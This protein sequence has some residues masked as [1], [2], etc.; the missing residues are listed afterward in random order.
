M[1]TVITPFQGTDPFS[2]ATFNNRISQINTGFSYIS[3]P[4]LLDN[5]YFGNPVDQRGG[6]IQFGG[7]MMY[8]DPELT[9]EFGASSGTTPVVMYSTYARPID[10]GIELKL[11]IKRSDCVRG[12][13]GAGYG[14]DRWKSETAETTL[15]ITS[16]GI[17]LVRGN[18]GVCYVIQKFPDYFKN[19]L[20]ETVTASYV[21]EN[22]KLH[23]VSFA[24]E[25]N[26]YKEYAT[27]GGFNIGFSAEPMRIVFVNNTPNSSAFAKAA[28]LELGP[29]QTLAHQDENGNWVLNEI[30]DY[31]EQLARCQRCAIRLSKW[32]RYRATSIEANVIDFSIP[33][34]VTMAGTPVIVDSSKFVVRTVGGVGLSGFTFSILGTGL[35][36]IGIRAIKENHGLTD[37]QLYVDDGAML[38]SDLF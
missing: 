11:Y 31:G 13:T 18:S 19:I 9:V 17:E 33:I 7:T 36:C 30:P 26:D 1:S 20:G 29:T 28:K 4:N 2:T 5:W 6:Y 12:Y 27:D 37:A 25:G 14:I 3:N 23:S 21:D 32:L 10:Q 38:A 8:K 22:D 34:P 24:F 16:K 35:N 15:L